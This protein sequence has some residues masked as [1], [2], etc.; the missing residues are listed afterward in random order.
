MMP[1]RAYKVLPKRQYRN[2]RGK[3]KSTAAHGL[4]RWTRLGGRMIEV[5]E[6]T[7]CRDAAI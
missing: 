1:H 6:F 7:E 3:R 5:R 2:T 4:D